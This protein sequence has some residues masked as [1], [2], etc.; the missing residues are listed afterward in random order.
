TPFLDADSHS[1]IVTTQAIR[2]SSLP[3]SKRG[4]MGSLESGFAALQTPHLFSHAKGNCE[5]RLSSYHRFFFLIIDQRF[6]A[7]ICVPEQKAFD[8]KKSTQ[9]S[10]PT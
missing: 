5:A 3:R 2:L 6:S 9:G 8:I 1:Q 7:F 4:E 10:V